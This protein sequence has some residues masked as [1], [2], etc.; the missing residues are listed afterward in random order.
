MR[1][2]ALLWLLCCL[3]SGCASYNPIITSQGPVATADA[4]G[5]H[6]RFAHSASIAAGSTS[7]T[8]SASEGSAQSTVAAKPAQIDAMLEDGFT[9]IYAN[10]SDFFRSSGTNQ[11]RVMLARDVVGLAGTLISGWLTI[12]DSSND[13]ALAFVTL[14]SASALS[15]LDI[16]TRRYLF[17]ADNVDSVRELTLV[18]LAAHANGVRTLRPP[19]TYQEA[20]VHLLDN[21]A[22]CTPSRIALLAREAIQQGKV[23]PF[24]PSDTDAVVLEAMD[25]AVLRR[26]GYSVGLHSPISDS[27]ATAYYWLL[28]ENPRQEELKSIQNALLG[29]PSSSNPFENDGSLKSIAPEREFLISELQRLSE[30]R[31]ASYA[32]VIASARKKLA[33]AGDEVKVTDLSPTEPAPALPPTLFKQIQSVR[34]RVE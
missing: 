22:I 26:I 4:P 13:D 14:G 3:F 11:T 33:S 1:K 28:F 31:R 15:V 30:K 16:Y 2:D 10:C 24:V 21:Q 7:S 19:S 18:A 12:S 29:V 9:L 20:S 32:S 27:A 17:G 5:F 25:R 23:V 6:G 34:I 8:R